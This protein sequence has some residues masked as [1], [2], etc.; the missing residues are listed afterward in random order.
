[1]TS[2]EFFANLCLMESQ[3]HIAKAY[4]L[5]ENKQMEIAALT[6]LQRYLNEIFDKAV[7]GDKNHLYL[8]GE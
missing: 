5:V 4:H 7:S 6:L 1:M 2:N 8:A 3:I